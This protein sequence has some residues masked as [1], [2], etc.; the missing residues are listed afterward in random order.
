MKRKRVRDSSGASRLEEITRAHT[1][2]GVDAS[3]TRI[4]VVEKGKTHLKR[5]KHDRREQRRLPPR[6]PPVSSHHPF[7]FPAQT[8]SKYL[9]P[10]IIDPIQA[11]A[12]A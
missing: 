6:A 12:A 9:A 1:Q 11:S 3:H 4:L 2:T 5:K 7:Q 10:S 8:S